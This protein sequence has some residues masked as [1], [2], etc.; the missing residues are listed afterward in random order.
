MEKHAGSR[1][2][3]FVMGVFA[4]F[5]YTLRGFDQ[6]KTAARIFRLYF[7]ER[8]RF[9]RVVAARMACLNSGGLSPSRCHYHRV[10][11]GDSGV[12]AIA[13][14]ADLRDLTSYL[15]DCR[16]QEKTVDQLVKE[17]LEQRQD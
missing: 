13:F 6:K 14:R 12:C 16:A 2:A 17:A 11:P 4:V 1:R 10:F 15:W 9:R 7:S 5:W 8:A 3:W